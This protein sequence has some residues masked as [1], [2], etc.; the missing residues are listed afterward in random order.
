MFLCIYI[1]TCLLGF[2]SSAILAVDPADYLEDS[3]ALIEEQQKRGK[4]LLLSTYVL[5]LI[6]LICVSFVKEDLKRLNYQN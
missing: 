6:A 5:H 1:V 3:E 2:G 4:I